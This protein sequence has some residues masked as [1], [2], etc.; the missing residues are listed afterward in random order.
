MYK[1]GCC[2]AF[3]CFRLGEKFIDIEVGSFKAMKLRLSENFQAT[4]DIVLGYRGRVVVVGMGKSGIIGK[5]I[6]ES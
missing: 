3:E 5:K 1:N 4:V 6:A 2:I